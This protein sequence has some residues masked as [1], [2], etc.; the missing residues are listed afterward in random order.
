MHTFLQIRSSSFRL[1][2]TY[3]LGDFDRGMIV[4]ARQTGLIISKTANH[5]GLSQS[6]E[7]TQNG[8]IEKLSNELGFCRQ[9]HLAGE[10]NGEWTD[11]TVTTLYNCGEQKSFWECTIEPWGGCATTANSH[12]G[13]NLC[14]PKTQVAVGTGLQKTEQLNKYFWKNIAWLK[15]LYF[16][17]GTQMVG[18]QF[19]SN[20]IN[21]WTKTIL[22]QQSKLVEVVS[23]CGEWLFDTPWTCYYQFIITWMPL[24]LFCIADHVYPFMVTI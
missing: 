3:N 24:S 14:L 22:C 2:V 19:D 16:Y 7:F 20:S 12:I 21:P 11:W 13:F 6:L 1:M 18:S 5:L 4:G 9:I 15:N 10:I 23:W 17:W 8:T